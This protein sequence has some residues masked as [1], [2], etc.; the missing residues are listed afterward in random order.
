MHDSI[1]APARHRR[2]FLGPLVALVVVFVAVIVLGSWNLSEYAITPGQ[3][4]PVAP[5]VTIS[6]LPTQT[7]HDR[8]M[9]V[10]VYLS[11]LDV[12]QWVKL[13]FQSHVQFVP[14]SDLLEPGI[15]SGELDAQGYLEMSDSKQAAEVAAFRALG[16]KIVGTPTGVIING[17][18]DPSPANSA[19]LKV[20]DEVV[21]V[22]GVA[23]RSTCAL[24][25]HVHALRPGTA[26]KLEV[27]KA[28]INAK[29]VISWASP[30][31]L[32]VTAAKAPGDLVASGCP[33]LKGPNRSWL[34]ITIE[35][36]TQFVLPAQ[37]SIN[38]ADIGGP[39]A[40]LAMTL[41]L[42][43][44]LSRGSLTGHHVIAATGTIAANGA[45]GDVGGVAQK[46]VAAQRAGVSIFFVPQVEVA[47]AKGA[48]G[49]GLRI[50]GVTSLRQVLKDLRRLGGAAPTAITKPH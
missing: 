14:A 1:S 27:M 36:A 8:I 42:I 41:T 12:W 39:S 19:G 18:A 5:L 44:Q 34:G 4:T 17:V 38:T 40:G 47:T 35:D 32:A 43:D 25:D 11:T 26:L 49:P 23:V 22:N 24:V 28:H 9:L 45:V 31:T 6:G 46:T 3:A 30:T 37:V 2:R 50:I 16:W 33:G 21:A 7:H 13:H 20:A 15:P 48:A 10:D 29:G